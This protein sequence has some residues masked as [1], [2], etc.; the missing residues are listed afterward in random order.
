MPSDGWTEP[1]Q[2]LNICADLRP[3]TNTIMSKT[4]SERFVTLVDDALTRVEE[5]TPEEVQD[6]LD[7]NDNFT[8]LDVR[9]Q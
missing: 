3:K 7:D 5:I 6:K 4:H 1:S 2:S 8:L 9:E